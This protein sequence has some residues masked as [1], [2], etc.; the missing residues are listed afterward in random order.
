MSTGLVICSAC[1]REVH[2]DGPAETVPLP[3]GKSYQ[4]STWRHCEDKSPLCEGASREFPQ[5][6]DEI[7]GKF[8][9]GDDDS[10]R[11]QYVATPEQRDVQAAARRSGK[12]LLTALALAGHGLTPPGSTLA[13]IRHVPGYRVRSTLTKA[14][15]DERRR[16]RKA[17]KAA[18]RRNRR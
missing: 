11:F 2:Q 15:Q 8:C 4:R 9:A 6:V 12:P 18:Q 5:A 16:R 14:E 7:R 1:K 3:D 10:G 17:R 13:D